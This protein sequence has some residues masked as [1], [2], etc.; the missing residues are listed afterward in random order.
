MIQSIIIQYVMFKMSLALFYPPDDGLAATVPITPAHHAALLQH[1]ANAA[2][3]GTAAR[4]LRTA[5][6]RFRPSAVRR[7]AVNGS[8][9]RNLC[10]LI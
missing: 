4:Q 9:S 5:A 3:M 8:G 6:T 2:A 7:K 1:G 10:L